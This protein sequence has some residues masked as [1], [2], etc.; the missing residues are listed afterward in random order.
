M[1]LFSNSKKKLSNHFYQSD[2]LEISWNLISSIK[3]AMRY[4]LSLVVEFTRSITL[5]WNS[6]Q[7]TAL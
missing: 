3:T 7:V 1:D 4:Y 5:C 2:S 6:S